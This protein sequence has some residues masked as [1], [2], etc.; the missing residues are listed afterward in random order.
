[1][2]QR[3]GSATIEELEED[4]AKI[5]RLPE[6]I[7]AVPHKSGTRSQF[8]YELAW[9]RTYLQKAGLA[10]NSA[11]GVWALTDQGEKAGRT[12][13][14][15]QRARL[16]RRPPTR[17][18]AGRRASAVPLGPQRLGFVFE[19]KGAGVGDL[20]QK[21]FGRDDDAAVLL[22]DRGFGPVI[23]R[24]ADVQAAIGRRAAAYALAALLDWRRIRRAVDG[25]AEEFEEKLREESREEAAVAFR[26]FAEPLVEWEE[27]RQELEKALRS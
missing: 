19:H 17:A 10:E 15:R 26:W 27:E 18:G 20:R 5:M 6:E 9:V 1:M 16:G 2:K 13:G 23:E 12:R 14:V 7:L 8:Q 3:G 22:S 25:A 11:R 24:I 4:V 21:G